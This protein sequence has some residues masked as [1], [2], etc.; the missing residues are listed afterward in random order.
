MSKKNK[1]ILA[2]GTRKSPDGK[3][4]MLLKVTAMTKYPYVPHKQNTP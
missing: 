3:T 4:T 1:K 2:K